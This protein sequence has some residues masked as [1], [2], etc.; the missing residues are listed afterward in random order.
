V[1]CLRPLRALWE[2]ELGGAA[3]GAV[4]D[5]YCERPE[6]R[7]QINQRIGVPLDRPYYNAGMLLIDTGRWRRDAIDRQIV[8]LFKDHG[9]RFDDQDAINVLLAAEIKPLARKWNFQAGKDMIPDGTE[10]IVHFVG[11]RKPWDLDSRNPLT[12]EFLEA[13]AHS[14]WR[15]K[16]RLP[17]KVRRLRYS[18]R[19]RM[20]TLHRWLGR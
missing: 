12:A 19:K 3:M 8:D 20:A 17:Y 11:G 7:R 1:I 14:P 10:A 9:G 18:H 15:W 6:H 2:T 13:K 5:I 4:P 16:P